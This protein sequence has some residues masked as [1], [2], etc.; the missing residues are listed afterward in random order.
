VRLQRVSSTRYTLTL[1]R[2]DMVAG[3]DGGSRR[4]V[5]ADT[6]LEWELVQRVEPARAEKIR[7]AADASAERGAALGRGC[8]RGCAYVLRH[9]SVAGDHSTPQ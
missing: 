8:D 2:V 5:T 9:C 1:S 4:S 3:D 6:A 7:A